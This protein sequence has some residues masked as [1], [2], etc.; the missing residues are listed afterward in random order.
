MEFRIVMLPP[1]TAATSGVTSEY[2]FS[3]QGVL[4]KF[5]DWFS[6]LQPLPKDN[7]RPRDFLC[8]NKEA[9]GV[10]WWYA[11]A[12]GMDAGGFQTLQFEGGCYLTYAYMDQDEEENARLYE[13]AMQFIADSGKFELDERPGRYSMG[14]IITPPEI[15]DA[16]GF[17]Q[18]EAFLPIRLKKRNKAD[19]S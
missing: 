12:E 6:T 1:F 11:L 18:M 10:E 14:H 8:W 15:T 7:F 19:R 16:C 9:G 3:P 2:D 13:A 5:N 4:G 17:A